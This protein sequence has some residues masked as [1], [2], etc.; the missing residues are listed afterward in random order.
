MALTIYHPAFHPAYLLDPAR[1]GL[2]TERFS[3]NDMG[4]SRFA[5]RTEKV[6]YL[7]SLSTLSEKISRKI[8][9]PFDVKPKFSDSLAK[10]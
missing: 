6:D 1:K 10:W 5:F 4:S 3:Q 2:E 8:A 9:F 7:W